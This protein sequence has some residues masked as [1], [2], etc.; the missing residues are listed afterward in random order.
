MPGTCHSYKRVPLCEL[1]LVASSFAPRDSPDSAK[2]CGDSAAVPMSCAML[3][4]KA[5]LARG[6]RAAQIKAE[7]TPNWK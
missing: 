6:R 2:S 3:E 5:L 4:R 7:L 1:G